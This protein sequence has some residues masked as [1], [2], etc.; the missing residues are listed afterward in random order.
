M[1]NCYSLIIKDEQQHPLN[2]GFYDNKPPIKPDLTG[3]TNC[4]PREEY[5]YTIVSIDPDGDDIASYMIDW[6]DNNIDIVEGPF[7]SGEEIIVDHE[8]SK[9]GIYNIRAKAKDINY[10][11]SDLDFLKNLKKEIYIIKRFT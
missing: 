9:R 2:T 5:N 7:S 6:G 10:F 1:V 11:D 8:W 4:N 3:P